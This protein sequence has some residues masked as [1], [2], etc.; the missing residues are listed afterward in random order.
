M[1]RRL[2]TFR[3]TEE[4]L[5]TEG[6]TTQKALERLAALQGQGSV[7]ATGNEPGDVSLE[8]QF[9]DDLAELFGTE[10]RELLQAPGIEYLEYYRVGGDSPDAGYYPAD[11][12]RGGRVQPQT[13]GVVGFDVSLVREGTRGSHRRRIKTR[14]ASVSHQWGTATDAP[15]GVPAAARDVQWLD[16]DGTARADATPG[17]TITTE[18]GDVDLYRADTAPTGDA[19]QLVYDLP[20]QD[21]GDTD[22]VVYDTWD[23]PELDPQGRFA[24]QQVYVTDHEYRGDVVIENGRIQ[25]VIDNSVDPHDVTVGGY[26][27]GAWQTVSLGTSDWRL[28]DIDVREIS[29]VAVRARTRWTDTG[30]SDTHSLDM[31]LHRG[32]TRAQFFEPTDS[33][34]SLIQSQQAPQGLVDRLDPIASTIRTD[35]DPRRG[36]IAREQL[37][38]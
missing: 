21:A 6:N 12:N 20:H 25:L 24:W 4:S 23:N 3:F 30:G 33:T 18:F 28:A 34:G 5:Q 26:T 38:L 13:G 2:Y 14:P 8:G 32:W 1:T 22:A 29:P 7:S 10:L 35:P 36:L 16:T 31:A 9:R 15:V 37:P 19:P 27:S 11:S 17:T